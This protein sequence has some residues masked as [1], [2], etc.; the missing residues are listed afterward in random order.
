MAR[1]AKKRH[2]DNLLDR[3]AVYP[4]PGVVRRSGGICAL[5]EQ[6]DAIAIYL[7]AV[8]GIPAVPVDGRGNC[9]IPRLPFLVGRHLMFRTYLNK[10]K[11]G[12]HHHGN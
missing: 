12:E 1:Q 5:D 8:E 4:D 10:L 2:H 7:D 6:A 11:N 3:L 9:R